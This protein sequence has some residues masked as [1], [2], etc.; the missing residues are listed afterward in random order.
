MT[1]LKTAL[2][3]IEVPLAVSW[4]WLKRSEG[5]RKLRFVVSTYS[6]SGVYLVR[7]GRQR[8]RH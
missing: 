8:A 5:K 4:F 6:Y 2:T 7:L 1:E 3:G